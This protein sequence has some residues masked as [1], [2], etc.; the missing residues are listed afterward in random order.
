M[1]TYYE[2]CQV[3]EGSG[4]VTETGIEAVCCGRRLD[5]GSCCGSPDPSPYPMQAQ[6]SACQATGFVPVPSQGEAERAIGFA[7]WI[8]LNYTLDRGLNEDGGIDWRDLEAGIYTTAELYEL[9]TT[10]STAK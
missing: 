9:F 7:E 5:D 3:C 8:R 6:C 2:K 1:K 10:Q 4:T